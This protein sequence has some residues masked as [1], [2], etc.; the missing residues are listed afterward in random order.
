MRGPTLDPRPPHVSQRHA[1]A[2]ASHAGAA[3][4]EDRGVDRSE[5]L[6]DLLDV[7]QGG[8][9]AAGVDRGQVIGGEHEADDVAGDRFAADGAVPGGHARHGRD[10]AVGPLSSVTAPYQGHETKYRL[11][12]GILRELKA[13]GLT[14]LQG[15]SAP[16]GRRPRR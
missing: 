15:H 10:A 16:L 12:R 14:V 3:E 2:N 4:E 1:Q 9:A 5:L 6:G 11:T 7:L 13:F 8:V